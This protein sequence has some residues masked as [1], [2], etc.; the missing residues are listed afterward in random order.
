MPKISLFKRQRKTSSAPAHHDSVQAW[1]PVQEIED[2][3]FYTKTKN[4]VAVLRVRPSSFSLLSERE[5]ERRIAA[6]FEAI[7]MIPGHIQIV[8]V[9]RP[10]D[11]DNYLRDLDSLHKDAHGTRKRLLRGYLSYVRSIAR[12]AE[13]MEKRF[14]ILIPGLP[15]AV[16]EL[17]AKA[18]ELEQHLARA[19]LVAHLCDYA[20]ILD[21]QYTFFHSAQSAFENLSE[22]V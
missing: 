13:A 7:Q 20:E 19:E 15:N 5:R 14:F 10:I 6:L 2:Y 17:L 4:P 18:K 16:D 12:G 11:L 3:Y 8:A 9:P 1:L 22:E 21:L